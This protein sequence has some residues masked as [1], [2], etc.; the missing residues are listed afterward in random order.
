VPKII[1]IIYSNNNFNAEYG[2][3]FGPKYGAIFGPKLDHLGNQIIRVTV[4]TVHYTVKKNTK[5]LGRLA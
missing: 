5:T 3:I 2:A 1:K 4:L